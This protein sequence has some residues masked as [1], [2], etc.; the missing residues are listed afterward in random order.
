MRGG[1]RR[2]V[3]REGPL[4]IALTEA[5]RCKGTAHNPKI[6]FDFAFPTR[7]HLILRSPEMEVLELS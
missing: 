7:R 6:L 3:T 4:Y 5:E 1:V 2:S